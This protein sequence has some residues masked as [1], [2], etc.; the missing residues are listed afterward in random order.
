VKSG[1]PPACWASTSSTARARRAPRGNSR[2]QHGPRRACS[3]SPLPI[4]RKV[5]VH[6]QT[7]PREAFWTAVLLAGRAQRAP[8]P[9]AGSLFAGRARSA[10]FPRRTRPPARFAKQGLTPARMPAPRVSFVAQGLSHPSVA[11]VNVSTVSSGDSATRVA[12]PDAGR[13]WTGPSRLLDPHR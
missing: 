10:H 2:T 8:I 9:S 3:V 13:A 6:A 11:P 7:A 1:A 4:H 12:N 5:P